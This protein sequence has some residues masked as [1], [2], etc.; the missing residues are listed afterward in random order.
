MAS[1]DDYLAD[2]DR[3]YGAASRDRLDRRLAGWRGRDGDPAALLYD[4]RRQLKAL[5]ADVAALLPKTEAV[6]DR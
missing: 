1:V 5:R 2:I 4:I 3:E 6:E